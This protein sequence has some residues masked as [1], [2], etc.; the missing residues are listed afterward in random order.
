MS[1]SKL[2]ELNEQIK[3]FDELQDSMHEAEKTAR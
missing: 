1:E 3:K 2:N